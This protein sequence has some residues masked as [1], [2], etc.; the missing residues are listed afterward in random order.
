MRPLHEGT[1]ASQTVKLC[2]LIEDLDAE[3]LMETFHC[4]A[5]HRK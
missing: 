5:A 3:T 1:C 2:K 4:D